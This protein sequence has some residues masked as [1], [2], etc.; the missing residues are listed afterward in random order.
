MTRPD[1]G[2]P[3]VVLVETP[4]GHE[5]GVS[6]ENG[7]LFLGRTSRGGPCKVTVFFGRTA[8]IENGTV[9]PIPGGFCRTNLAIHAPFV[10]FLTEYPRADEPLFLLGVRNGRVYRQD[11][12]WAADPDVA[13]NVL[14][15]P[16]GF[17][18]DQVGAPIL[19]ERDERLFLVGLAKAT[20]VLHG[21]AGGERRFL[22]FAG[23]DQIR[24]A[25]LE[26]RPAVLEQEVFYRDDEVRVLRERK[27]HE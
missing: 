15:Y 25:M 8:V 23:L 24:E 2:G 27:E 9:T 6:T 18:S 11:V 14:E 26:I 7:V 22:S 19:V 17:S 13:G 12:R 1:N 5:L 3:P 10:P 16:G 20:A 21:A 4:G